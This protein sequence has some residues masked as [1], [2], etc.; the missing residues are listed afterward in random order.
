MYTYVLCAYMYGMYNTYEWM[1]STI[2][3]LYIYGIM[4]A[5]NIFPICTFST[6]IVSLSIYIYKT[7]AYRARKQESQRKTRK[8]NPVWLSVVK[9]RRA[10]FSFCTC[11][12]ALVYVCV[13]CKTSCYTVIQVFLCVCVCMDM[14]ADE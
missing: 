3:S 4:H 13:L 12:C 14:C 11:M 7:C 1:F 2:K 10:C 9:I 6:A 8:A 5:A